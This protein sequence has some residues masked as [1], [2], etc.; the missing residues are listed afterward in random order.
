MQD[1]RI[2]I[3]VD[4]AK[5]ELVI[6]GMPGCKSVVALE[7]SAVAIRQWLKTVPAGSSIAMESTG[8]YHVEL[9]RLA[10]AALFEV[11]VLN[12]KDVWFASQGEGRRA[13]TDRLDAQVIKNYLEEHITKLHPWAP[14]TRP[15]QR[16]EELI[17]RRATIIVHQVAIRK[18]L[19]G[20]EGMGRQACCVDKHIAH[21]LETIDAKVQSLIA[22]DE[23]MTAVQNRLLT[24]AGIGPQC[25][26]TLTA[27]LERIPF[28]DVNAF[29]AFSGLDPRPRDSGKKRGV[30]VLTKRG[31]PSLRRLAYMAAFAACRT[32]V[33]KPVYQAIRARG[34]SSTEAF[35]ILARKILRIAWAVWKSGLPFD[36]SKAVFR[37]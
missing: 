31:P 36:P 11:F 27:L 14:G 24:I 33:F 9:A 23:T 7:N 5:D 4:V 13:K 20:V 3:G 8:R 21:L 1:E 37:A 17:R 15:Q 10:H 25:S 26:A 28:K 19:E 30:R 22:Q 18:A 32:K 29:V 12:A 2:L 35:V 16:I 34:F 6:A